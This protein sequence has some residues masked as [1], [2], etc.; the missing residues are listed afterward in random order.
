MI[1]CFE[2]PHTGDIAVLLHGLPNNAQLWRKQLGLLEKHFH[3]LNF[4]FNA[5]DSLDQIKLT[6]RERVQELLWLHP[7]K[8]V[9]LLGHDIGC[10]ILEEVGHELGENVRAQI[11][12]SGM[13]F[14]QFCERLKGS[15]QLV[16]SS[17]AFLL[18]IPGMGQLTER[19]LSEQLAQHLYRNSDPSLLME[20]P[21]GFKNL[22]LYH[23]LARKLIGTL[24]TPAANPSRVPT[25]F[26]FGS[27]DPYLSLPTSD[28]L[29]RFH[30]T[31]SQHILPGGHWI[32][33]ERVDGVNH[34]IARFLELTA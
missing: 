23:M 8:K 13:G 30:H 34:S 7:S 18:A 2:T 4:E 32:N 15:A 11:F 28:E 3:V 16:K 31:S 6:I 19:L 25:H 5:P 20:A 14:P 33:R 29:K 21:E 12:I 9:V 24:R 22:G 27:H 26:I 17:Y 10:F 1:S